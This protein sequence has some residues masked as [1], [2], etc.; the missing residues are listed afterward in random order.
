MRRRIK[1]KKGRSVSGFETIHYSRKG[2]LR[3]RERR[4]RDGQRK[5]RK[6][7]MCSSTVW[8]TVTCGLSLLSSFPLEDFA[9]L[10]L[11]MDGWME[12]GKEKESNEQLRALGWTVN[13]QRHG[14]TPQRLVRISIYTFTLKQKSE[15]LIIF[16]VRRSSHHVSVRFQ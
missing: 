10:T 15:K 3:E 13:S 9:M 16:L 1:T 11:K 7:E 12:G 8:L 4:K 5:K 14:K 6:G 2:E